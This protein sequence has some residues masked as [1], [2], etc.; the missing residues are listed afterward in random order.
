[1]IERKKGGSI[2]NVSSQASLRGI[3][4]HTLYGA[5]K[6]ALDALT[7]NMCLELGPHNVNV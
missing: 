7:R 1:M 2:V 4:D 5:T 6:A 3:R